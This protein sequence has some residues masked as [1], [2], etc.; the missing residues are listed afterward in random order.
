MQMSY[1]E[2]AK[3]YNMS[4]T[5]LLAMFRENSEWWTDQVASEQQKEK[6]SEE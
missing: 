2:Q 4:L 5:D 6:E 3:R 1:E